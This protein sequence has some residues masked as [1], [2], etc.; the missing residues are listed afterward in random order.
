ME[1]RTEGQPP[2]DDAA[3]P[4]DDQ[5][6]DDADDFT[7][8]AIDERAMSEAMKA[9]EQ[10]YQEALTKPNKASVTARV[11]AKAKAEIKAQEKAMKDADA[12][13]IAQ[14]RTTITRYLECFPSLAS[15]VPK[16]SAKPTVGEVDGVLEAIRETRMSENSMSHMAQMIGMG[17][18]LLESLSS[19]PVVRARLPPALQLDL[20]GLSDLYMSRKL[21]EL[22]PI[23]MELDIE[24]PMI[25]RRPLWFRA[26]VAFAG[27]IGRV[28]MLNTNQ[29]AKKAFEMEGHAPVDVSDDARD[30]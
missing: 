27:V 4:Q 9:E 11:T 18:G 14:S 26:A 6:L 17:F 2:S 10:M 30:L 16:L 19:N 15:R 5:F 29:L 13:Y 3:Q 8:T 21:P 22:D 24:Y 23:I 25:G 7:V 12:L 1:S 28:H 20:T